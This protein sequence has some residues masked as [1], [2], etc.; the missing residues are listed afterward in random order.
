MYKR[1][2]SCNDVAEG[3]VLMLEY[4]FKNKLNF[5]NLNLGTGK[6]TS[7]LEL[8]SIFEEV[9]SIKLKFEY[10]DRRVGDV[11]RL[12]ADNSLA[13]NIKLGTEI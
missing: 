8:L 5:L 13:K 1:L 7:V 3:H 12:V 6:G 11:D 10:S 9:N 4:L 2:Y